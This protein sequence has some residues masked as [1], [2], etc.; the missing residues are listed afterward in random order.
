MTFLE[1][2]QRLSSEAGI[3]GT[4]PSAV[5]GQT[6]LNLRLVNWTISAWNDIQQRRNDWLWMRGDFSFPTV[7]AQAEY[8]STEAG[9]TERF[10]SWDLQSVKVYRSSISDETKLDYL[11]YEMWRDIYLVGQRTPGRPVNVTQTPD[12]KLGLGHFPDAVYT[13][14]G[15]YRKSP[16]VLAADADEP[17]FDVEYHDSIWYRALMKYA[18]FYAAAEIYDDA[19]TEY[20]NIMTKL[21]NE[22]AP[23]FYLGGTLV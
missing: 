9:I 6:G 7:A 8:T 16:Q 10:R 19:K 23:E 21:E 12:K 15:K 1:L 22:Q 18:R 20:L 5:T 13:I 11:P 4:G 3:S 17:E 2:V 14:T